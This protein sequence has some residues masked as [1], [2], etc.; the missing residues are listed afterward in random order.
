MSLDQTIPYCDQIVI[1]TFAVVAVSIIV[2]GSTM[3][4]LVHQLGIACEPTGQ[5]G[6]PSETQ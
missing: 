1:A 4:V 5:G 6:M 2:Q 3:P